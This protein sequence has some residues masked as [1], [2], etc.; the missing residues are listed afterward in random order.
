MKAFLPVEDTKCAEH[1]VQPSSSA[2]ATRQLRNRQCSRHHSRILRASAP[3]K[4]AIA[5]MRFVFA[6]NTLL[7]SNRIIAF[8]KLF[9]SG[10]VWGIT[11]RTTAHVTGWFRYPHACHSLSLVRLVQATAPRSAVY[12]LSR[13]Q[14]LHRLQEPDSI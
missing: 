7:L 6:S 12:H 4:L 3:P 10:F 14:S 8:T 5:V 11:C 2:A 13:S 9:D 1:S